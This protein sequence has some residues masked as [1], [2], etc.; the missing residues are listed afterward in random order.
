MKTTVIIIGGGL[1]GLTAARHLGARGIDFRLIEARDRL[2]GRVLSAHASGGPASD[3]FDLGPSWFWPDLQPAMRRL[4]SELGLPSFPQHSDGDRLIQWMG[5]EAPRRFPGLRQEPES[6][7]LTGGIGR[8]V[9]ALAAELP[10]NR[11]QLGTRLTQ[12][13]LDGSTVCAEFTCTDGH[14]QRINGDYLLLAMPPRLLEADVRFIPALSEATRH[15]WRRT[16]TWMA[17]H[18]KFVA[19]YERPFWREAGLSGMA[20]SQLGPLTEVHDATTASGAPALFGFVGLAA[21]QRA[22]IGEAALVRA[23]IA[24]LV[25]LFGAEA[26]HPLAALYKDWATD[27][28]TATAEDAHA[29][30]HPVPGGLAVAPP[31]W[32]KRLWLGGSEVA[33]RDAGYLAGAVEAAEHAARQIIEQLEKAP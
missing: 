23:S 31:E 14:L 32:R 18:A 26:G 27:P 6:M 2:G 7:R 20:Q 21:H 8:L 16:P 24:Q 4:V 30:D 22:N 5:S 17:P 11:I 25:Q 10:Q 28:L 15:A 33:L 3:G 13:T 9:S 1:A 12:V 19:V 29:G